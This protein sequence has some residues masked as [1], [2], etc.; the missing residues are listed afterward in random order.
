MITAIYPGS[1]DPMTLGHLDIID[2]AAKI[3]D[4]LIVSV[5]V[6]VDK[7][8]LFSVDERMEQLRRVLHSYP[9]IE[10]DCSSA[11]MSD[12]AEQF[13]NPVIVKG[14]R[15]QIDY[16][17]EATMAVY[18]RKLNPKLPLETFLINADQRYIYHSS[19]AVKQLAMYGSDL[20]DYVP[21]EI[22]E[23]LETQIR[24]WR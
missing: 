11:L 1:F 10:I 9:N 16:E 4:K 15:N 8:F 20:T 13:E 5:V 23:D 24:N 3:F 14:I 18:N 19:T 6:N 12:Y 2:R 22:I 21:R 7:K 17:Y